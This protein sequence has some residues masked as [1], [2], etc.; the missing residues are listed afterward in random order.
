MKMMSQLEDNGVWVA[1][2]NKER[3]QTSNCRLTFITAN[4]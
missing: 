1:R 3:E 2:K 4:I